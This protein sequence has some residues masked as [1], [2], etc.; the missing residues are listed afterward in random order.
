MGAD[1]SSEII[2]MDHARDARSSCGIEHVQQARDGIGAKKDVAKNDEHIVVADKIGRQPHGMGGAFGLRLFDVGDLTA[3]ALAL[4]KVIA[5]PAPAMPHHN[6]DVGDLGVDQARDCP[7]NQRA[8]ADGEHG[9]GAKHIK[10]KKTLAFA[11]CENECFHLATP[12]HK[13]F[14]F[15]QSF[16]SIHPDRA[17]PK[18][19]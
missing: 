10:R 1:M 4:A 18:Q 9:L 5:R 13:N 16:H 11:G 6:A 17:I 15:F 12:P 19:R 2:D 8:V 7:R 3:K 14:S